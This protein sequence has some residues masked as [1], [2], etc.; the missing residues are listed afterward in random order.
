[1]GAMGSD[2]AIEAADIVI[3]NDEPS[4]IITAIKLA[5]KTIKIANQNMLVAFGVKVLALILS[6]LGIADM[7]MAV[8]ADVGVTIIAV[9]NSFRALKIDK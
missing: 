6:A 3:M 9:L 5:R 8:F 1:M 2:A 4:K 7:W